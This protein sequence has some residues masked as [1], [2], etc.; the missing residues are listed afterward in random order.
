M[1]VLIAAKGPAGV[2]LITDARRPTGM[3][4]GEYRL[5][6]G[7]VTARNGEVRLPDGTLAGSMLRMNLALRNVADATGLSLQELWPTTSLN[8]A[9]AIGLSAKK[10]SIEAGKDA[11]LTLLDDQFDVA[12]T[13]V[14]G[15]VVFERGVSADCR[16]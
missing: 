12:L 16:P 13:V 1:R 7:T 8:A 9:R 15:S 3:P 5:D 10:G 2:I 11:D 14:E 6:S 4:D